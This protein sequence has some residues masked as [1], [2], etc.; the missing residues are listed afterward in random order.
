MHQNL[1]FWRQNMEEQKKK[2]NFHIIRNIIL[3]VLFIIMPGIRGYNNYAWYEY[4]LFV[5]LPVAY[6]IYDIRQETKKN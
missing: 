4:L 6:L 2:R 1:D 3:I 5:F